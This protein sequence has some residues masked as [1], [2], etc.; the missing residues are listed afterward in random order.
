[1][2]STAPAILEP[3]VPK[4]SGDIGVR[5]SRRTALRRF[6][7]PGPRLLGLVIFGAIVAMAL[8]SLVWTPY[9]FFR[10][11]VAVPYS[12]PSPDNLLGV[13]QAG[14][15][16]LSRLMVG[17][18]V[19]LIVAFGTQLIAVPFGVAFG[20]IA[21]YFGGRVDAIASTIVNVFYGIPGILVAMLLVL[22]LGAGVDKVVLAIAITSW[23]DV[24][25]LARS[26]MLALKERPFIEAARALGVSG[27]RTMWRHILPNCVG[28]LIV[29]ATYGLA[30]AILYEAFLS[31]LGLGVAPPMPSWGSMTAD[32]FAAVR[33]APHIVVAPAIAISLTL[34][35]ISFIGDGIASDLDATTSGSRAAG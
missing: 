2:G 35:A 14:R 6:A 15:D 4:D 3:L 16:I 13:D 27:R 26:Q 31:Y 7:R 11:G 21:G 5:P 9:P 17:A 24:S 32:G 29:T 30:A 18:R 8:V 12:G 22:M 10:Q 25:R 33:L 20:F 1:M 28:P 19:S 23:M 34:V